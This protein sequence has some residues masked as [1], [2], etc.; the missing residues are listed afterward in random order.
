MAKLTDKQRKKIIAEYVEG[1]TSLRKLA[2]K[3][4][5]SD[6]LIRRILNSD[7]KLTQKIAKKKEENT[8]S[9]LAFMD[10]KKDDVCS[11]IGKILAAMDDPEKIAAT[12]LKDLAVT[13]GV[14][15][16]KFTANETLNTA[17]GKDNNL[18][19]AINACSEEGLDDLP[20]VRDAAENDAP[21]VEDG[22]PEE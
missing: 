1:G 4:G 18:F 2:A 3:Y 14:I 6:Y 10:S 9:V 7:K 22:E 16:D 5:V 8:A 21:L 15:I 11:L 17:S 19:E 20:E 13:S 12:S